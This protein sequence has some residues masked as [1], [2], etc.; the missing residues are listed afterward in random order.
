MFTCTFSLV[1]IQC[2]VNALFA[3]ISEFVSDHVF[4]TIALNRRLI[5]IWYK[6]D[7]NFIQIWYNVFSICSFSVMQFQSVSRDTTPQR[8]YIMSATTYLTAMVSSNRALQ[9]VNYPTQVIGKS[10]KPI[11]VMILGALYARKKYPFKKYCFILTIVAGVV[12][13]VIK[14]SSKVQDETSFFGYFLLVSW[15]FGLVGTLG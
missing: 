5:Q 4:D 14:D 12:L 9:Y 15:Y 3:R 6:F 7:T 11:P 2:V 8:Y 1:L 10:C 13:F